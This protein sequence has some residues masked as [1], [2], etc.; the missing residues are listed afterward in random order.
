[1]RTTLFFCS[2][3]FRFRFSSKTTQPLKYMHIIGK[4]PSMM[5]RLSCILRRPCLHVYLFLH[6]SAQHPPCLPPLP[7]RQA[8]CLPAYLPACLTTSLPWRTPAWFPDYLHACL[9]HHL[10]ANLGAC[11][12]RHLP[13]CFVAR[14]LLPLCKQ[15]CCV[16]C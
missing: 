4:L 3:I 7:T 12:P 16:H 2:T 6:A 10:S 5:M 13:T 14:C 9:P 8:G 1:M 15:H 11:L